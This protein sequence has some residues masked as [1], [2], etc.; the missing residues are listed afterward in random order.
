MKTSLSARGVKLLAAAAGA[1][2][3]LAVPNVA[4]AEPIQHD[5]S[6]GEVQLYAESGGCPGHVITGSTTD[7]DNKIL[8]ESGEH[9]ITI[10]D[11]SIQFDSYDLLLRGDSPFAIGGNATVNLTIEGANSFQA[12]VNGGDLN[13]AVPGIWVQP[14]STLNIDGTGSLVARA[15][16]P[17]TTGQT[18]AAGIGAVP[19]TRTSAI[20]TLAAAISKP[21]ALAVVLALA[22]AM[23]SV[24]APKM[25][26]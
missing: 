26:M 11:V 10:R 17:G 4:I 1:V 22:V 12:H 18:G 15:A 9:N 23:S 14:G 7:P 20:S 24:S 6:Q 2:M 8:V 19:I 21:M 16:D 5:I 25:V 3:L 13:S